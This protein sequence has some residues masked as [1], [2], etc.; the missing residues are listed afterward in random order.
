MLIK[1]SLVILAVISTSVLAATPVTEIH[2]SGSYNNEVSINILTKSEPS[3]TRDTW[4]NEDGEFCW[5]DQ[6]GS[7]DCT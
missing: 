1:M 2:T 7:V 5:I 6:G 4:I 3:F